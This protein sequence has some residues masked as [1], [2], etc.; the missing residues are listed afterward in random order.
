MAFNRLVML[1]MVVV[2]LS[3]AVVAADSLLGTCVSTLPMQENAQKSCDD[4]AGLR[5]T[6]PA[7]NQCAAWASPPSGT[8]KKWT[9]NL[10]VGTCKTDL[11]SEGAVPSCWTCLS[12]AEFTDYEYCA[13][14]K[15]YNNLD[16]CQNDVNGVDAWAYSAGICT[17]T[18][19]E[20]K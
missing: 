10:L 15:K 7:A 1:T 8:Q 14:G 6:T 11:G 4:S 13:S 18:T 12:N 19:Y 9:S 16:D 2:T 3:G 17:K 5:C 20:G